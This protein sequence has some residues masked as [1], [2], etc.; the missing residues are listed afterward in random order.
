M[1]ETD[2]AIPE[3]LQRWANLCE[4]SARR[5]EAG[6]DKDELDELYVGIEAAWL[7]APWFDRRRFDVHV[8]RGIGKEFCAVLLERINA[9]KG[10]A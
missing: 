7:D 3:S 8:L 9:R 1:S 4:H 6:A 2:E 5:E 10:A